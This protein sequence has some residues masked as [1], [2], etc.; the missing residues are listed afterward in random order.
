MLYRKDTTSP[1]YLHSTLHHQALGLEVYTLIHPEG[2]EE[3]PS[4]RV[5]IEGHCQKAENYNVL[6]ISLHFYPGKKICV[7]QRIK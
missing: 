6:I 2:R 3:I 7:I 4:R 1:C 5:P